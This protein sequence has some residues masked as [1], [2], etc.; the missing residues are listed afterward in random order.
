[1]L[2]YT[3]NTG[4]SHES[5]RCEVNDVAIAALRPFLQPGWH[6]VPE[7][8]DYECHTMID[9]GLIS[10]VSHSPSKRECVLF[11]VA[12]TDEQAEQ[13][14]KTIDNAYQRLSHERPFR[15]ADFA[16]ACRPAAAPWC[17]TITILASSAEGV[18]IA[19]FQCDLAWAW[20]ELG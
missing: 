19:R 15:G 16:P 9:G 5:P 3:L 13:T 11:G 4:Q 8:A 20:I 12:K 2:H 18:W 17:A 6:V 1:M 7:P 10:N 14:W